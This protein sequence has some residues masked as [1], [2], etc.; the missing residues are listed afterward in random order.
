MTEQ[1]KEA[2]AIC[3]PKAV[4][5]NRTKTA[6]IKSADRDLLWLI[7]KEI[8]NRVLDKG[9]DS[10]IK[11]SLGRLFQY[12]TQKLEAEAAVAKITRKPKPQPENQQSDDLGKM[13]YNELRKLAKAKNF[14]GNSNP[15]KAELIKFLE[16]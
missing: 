15:T 14:A 10:C 11:S 4:Q 9:C 13:S 6:A 12:Q 2:V 7:E 3:Y 1:L 16:L 5:F 8:F